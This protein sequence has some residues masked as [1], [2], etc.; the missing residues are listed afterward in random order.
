MAARLAC[1]RAASDPRTFVE[2]NGTTTFASHLRR[3]RRAAGLTQEELAER[4]GLSPRAISD[5]ER[6]TRRAPHRDTLERLAG[7]LELSSLQRDALDRSVSRRRGVPSAPA[8]RAPVR[9]LPADLTPLVGR[10]R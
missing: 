10:E 4:A 3:L 1:P 2:S 8:A 5:L 9:G 7:A 6:G